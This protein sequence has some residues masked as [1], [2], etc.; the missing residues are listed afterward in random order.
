MKSLFFDVSVARILAT[1]ALGRYFPSVY[2]SR[3]SPVRYAELPEP[4]LPG[5][6]WVRVKPKLAGICG[7]D[8]SLFFVKASPSISIAA[9]PGV[10]RAFMGHELIGTVDEV[11][12]GV[13]G[14]KAGDRVT[15]QRYL[16]C[17]SMLEIDPPC[18]PCRAGNYT[19]CENFSAGK[20]PAN[21]GAGFSERFVA[22][23]SQL[24]KVPDAISDE[25]AVLIEPASVS[26]HAV[27][28]RPPL[29]GEKV[30][31]IGAG[32][33]GLGVIQFARAICPEAVI[34]V[35]ERIPFKQDLA[36][37]L[38]ADFVLEGD[39]YDAAAKATGGKVYRG[40]LKNTT[41]LGGFDL[42]YD[43]VGYNATVHDSLRWLK[44]RGAYVMIGNQLS[45]IT[46]DQTPLWNQ[47]LTMLGVNAHGMETY[48]ERTLSSFGLAME[49]I[50]DKRI[51]LDGFIT[52]RFQL[53]DYQAA[54]RLA[55]EK[56]GHVIKVIFEM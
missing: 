20:M 19:L 9:L 46:F 50:A 31:V 49:M 27:L 26:L 48:Q 21:L 2:F 5:A 40:P 3:L 53:D 32:T 41:M 30:L 37:R 51:T 11:G 35:L 10:P 16:P 22:H 28:R 6:H 39:P 17:C 13:K 14:L 42:I 55:L 4:K 25:Q 56:P 23:A 34:H 15:M 29:S 33:I 43:C 38:G 45:P 1:K 54:F 44:S 12:S 36:R 47:E 8:L 7:A 52:Q 18:G 24:I